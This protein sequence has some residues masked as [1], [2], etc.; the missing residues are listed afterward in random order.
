MK[1]PRP[2]MLAGALI[3]LGAAV[4]LGP[5]YAA[6]C[7]GPVDT[8][9]AIAAARD[10]AAQ[11]AQAAAPASAPAGLAHIQA[12]ALSLVLVVKQADYVSFPAHVAAGLALEA[13]RCPLSSSGDQWRKAAGHA[14]ADWPAQVAAAG[15]ARTLGRFEG[16]ERTLALLRAYAASEPWHAAKLAR[17]IAAFQGPSVG[18][19]RQ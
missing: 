18:G 19:V 11:E 8:Y 12:G 9:P 3:V 2:A 1:G 14:W 5:G 4:F 7:A 13:G 15:L 16:P 17:V 6:L 10:Q